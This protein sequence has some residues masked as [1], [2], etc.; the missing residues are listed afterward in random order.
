MAAWSPSHVDW[1][2][3]NRSAYQEVCWQERWKLEK[4]G[5]LNSSCGKPQGGKFD[6]GWSGF[7][8][9]VWRY[10]WVRHYLSARDCSVVAK[11]AV[12]IVVTTHACTDSIQGE[13]ARGTHLL[14]QTRRLFF[15]LF[16]CSLLRV[17][18]RLFKFWVQVVEDHSK[19]TA[20]YLRLEWPM[21]C[22]RSR[23]V[24]QWCSTQR[25]V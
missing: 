7:S 4:K 22:I 6:V 3:R 1:H 8:S 21:C 12:R 24:D 5:M 14:W 17:S 9:E 25:S 13:G 11:N 18:K 19:L 15:G 2:D 23:L 20:S 10:T 16:R